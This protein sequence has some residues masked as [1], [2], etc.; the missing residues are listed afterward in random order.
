MNKRDLSVLASELLTE[1]IPADNLLK[2]KADTCFEMAIGAVREYV[3]NPSLDVVEMFPY[4]IAQLT[5]HFYKTFDDMNIK[6][7]TQGNRDVEYFSTDIP[8]YI[9]RSLPRFAQ[10]F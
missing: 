10:G 5:V 2:H 4:Q 7:K 9:K 8:D 1:S 3:H 6:S